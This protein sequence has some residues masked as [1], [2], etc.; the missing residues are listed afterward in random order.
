[1]KL[2]VKEEVGVGL[3]RVKRWSRGMTMMKMHCMTLSKNVFKLMHQVL[4][5]PRHIASL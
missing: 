4:P 2:G 3:R 5:G 1:M